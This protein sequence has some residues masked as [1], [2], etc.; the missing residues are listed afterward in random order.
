VV[1]VAKPEAD[2]VIATLAAHG[3]PAQVIGDIVE[4]AEGAAHTIVV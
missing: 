1:V 2:K 3:Q 4:R